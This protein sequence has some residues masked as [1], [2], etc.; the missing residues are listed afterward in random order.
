MQAAEG[1]GGPGVTAFVRQWA[2]ERR[3]WAYGRHGS[4]MGCEVLSLYL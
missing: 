3:V 1:D 4:V 2:R